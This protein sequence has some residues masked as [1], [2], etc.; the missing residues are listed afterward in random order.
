MSEL[1]VVRFEPG[2]D[3]VQRFK[4]EAQRNLA[5]VHENEFALADLLV[6]RK[7][8]IAWE[9]PS[10]L[11]ALNDAGVALAARNQWGVADI[12]ITGADA[13]IAATGSLILRSGP[14]RPRAASLL[15]PVH[16]A[17]LHRERITQSIE[18]WL[19]ENGTSL[20]DSANTVFVSGPSRS[21]DI[22][23]ILT[24]GVHG[25]GEVHIVLVD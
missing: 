1:E 12:G 25:P 9:D 11:R 17:I 8:A 10:I 13:G 18:S 15:P 16:V 3:L 2:E 7:L 20:S 23:M 21:G 4:S 22:E 14:G 24:L 19:A 6:G 5:V